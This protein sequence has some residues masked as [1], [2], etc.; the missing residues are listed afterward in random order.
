MNDLARVG[1]GC[2]HHEPGFVK[3]QRGS[4]LWSC[5]SIRPL[6][7]PLITVRRPLSLPLTRPSLMMDPLSLPP[8]LRGDDGRHRGPMAPG[9]ARRREDRAG[10]TRQDGRVPGPGLQGR[11]IGWVR[12]LLGGPPAMGAVPAGGS[13]PCMTSQCQIHTSNANPPPHMHTPKHKG[14]P[15]ESHR[16]HPSIRIRSLRC[17]FG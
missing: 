4:H 10:V 8:G 12:C 11:W 9:E 17:E 14:F 15:G 7:L 2:M 5:L 16:P 1:W 13:Q 3:R 6:S